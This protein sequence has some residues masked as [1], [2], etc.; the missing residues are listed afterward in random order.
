MIGPKRELT[1]LD[2]IYL[3][4][5]V[6][7]GAGVYSFAPQI[8]SAVPT[9]GHVLGL[10]ALGGALSLLGALCYAELAAAYPKEG[11]DYVYLSRAYGPWAG[12][13]FGWCQLSVVRPGDIATISFVFATHAEAFLPDSLIEN[14]RTDWK[15]ALAAL[16]VWTLTGI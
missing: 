12:F 4:V 16:A 3:I 14:S 13:L 10:W 9:S 8:A 7:I 15:R 11:G 6:I 1:L 5:G 2:A